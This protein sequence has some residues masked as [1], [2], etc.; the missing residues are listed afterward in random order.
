MK[1]VKSSQ[2][3]YVLDD[4]ENI[5]DLGNCKLKEAKKIAQETA[6]KNNKPVFI[7]RTIGYIDPES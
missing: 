4:G 2:D 1:Y 6:K 7:M 3:E 5:N